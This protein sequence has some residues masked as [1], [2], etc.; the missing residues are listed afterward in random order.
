MLRMRYTL[1][2]GVL[3]YNTYGGDMKRA[4]YRFSESYSFTGTIPCFTY[5]PK[6]MHRKIDNQISVILD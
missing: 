2:Q 4:W 6:K 1:E 3:M 5:T